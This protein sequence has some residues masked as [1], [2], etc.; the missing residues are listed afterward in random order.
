ML[1]PPVDDVTS[2]R[3]CLAPTPYPSLTLSSLSLFPFLFFF[4][5]VLLLLFAFFIF[6]FYCVPVNM[7]LWFCCVLCL[8]LKVRLTVLLSL[9]RFLLPC[10]CIFFPNPRVVF[11]HVVEA[12]DWCSA[13]L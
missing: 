12:L 4:V 8:L 10:F 9:I 13:I 7:G 1:P 5:A 3:C 2:V 6:Y 11:G